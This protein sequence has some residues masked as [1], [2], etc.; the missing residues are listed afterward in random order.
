MSRCANE[1][2]LSDPPASPKADGVS[3][4]R[5][6]SASQASV[7]P[8]SR[9]SCPA[10]SRSMPVTKAGSIRVHGPL[11]NRCVGSGMYPSSAP[12]T[13][14]GTPTAPANSA[15]PTPS[16]EEPSRPASASEIPPTGSFVKILKRIPKASREQC[17]KKL[18]SI[19]D[20]C[21][22]KN[23]HTVWDRLLRFSSRCLRAPRRGGK[24]RSLASAINKQLNEEVDDP[25]ITSAATASHR[26]V[27][28]SPSQDPTKYLATRV[29]LKLEEGDFRGAVRLACSD[30]SL[31]DMTETTYTALQQKH[32]AP[33]PQSSIPQ[34][35][36]RLSFPPV[37]EGEIAQAI[38]SFPNGSAGGPD[39][40]RPQH[41]KD[42]IATGAGVGCEALLCALVPFIE[43]VLSGNTPVSIR[44]FFFGANLIALQKKDGGIRPI[45]V[46]C[47]LRRLAAKVAGM[48]VVDQMATLLAP[49][50]LGYGVRNG[51]EAAVHAARMYLSNPDPS[52]AF[53]KLDFQNA[54]NS[55]RR[56]KMLQ[57]IQELA[58]VLTA[59]AHSAYSL[60]STL[61]WGDKIL[62][63]AEGVQQG[64]P[65]GPLFFCLSIHQLCSSLKSEF[66]VFYLDDC[67]LGGPME[68]VLHDLNIVEREGA[69]LGLHLNYRKS[70]VIGVDKD[71]RDAILSFL[72]GARVVDPLRATLLGSPIGDVSSISITLREKIKLLETL[73]GRLKHLFTHDA[74]I[75]L[76]H[77]LAIPKLLHNLRTSP[78]FLSPTLQDYDELLKST[79]SS[80]ANIRFNEN[81]PAWTQ[82][83]LPVRCGGLG[84]RS[85]VQL[86]PSAFLASA[87]ACSDMIHNIIPSHLQGTPV[88]NVSDAKALWTHGHDMPPPEA[89]AQQVQRSWD[90]IKVT[91]TAERLLE[92]ASDER[93]QARLR[94]AFSKESGAWLQALP[95]SSLGL[96]MDDNTVRVAIGL[97]LGSPLCRPHICH[98]CGVEVDCSA[99][100]GLHCRWS[101]GRHYRHAALNDIVHRALSA[102][103]IPSR[104]EPVGIY[105]SDGKR[106][107]GI[108]VVP[109]ERGQLLVWDA[110]CSD[111]FAPSY[112][113]YATREAGA[114]AAL[115]EERKKA[116]YQH[117][118]ASHCF[119]PIA[120]ETAGAFG[121]QTRAFLK[122]LG[123]RI[124]RATGDERSHS[125]L[126]QRVSVAIQRGNAA[127]VAGTSGQSASLDCFL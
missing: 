8:S 38:K 7:L 40:L 66:S 22:E 102:A 13:V 25:S 3:Q 106:P 36:E 89:N 56:D 53:L 6:G 125:Y 67:S 12:N 120:V 108:T 122:D 121:P 98:H 92:N 52:I 33:H 83:T 119:V 11:G 37:T 65:L 24:R 57:A 73:G 17:G 76:R 109:W 104:L 48:K 62:Q 18:A 126:I 88:P 42:L 31:A 41:L 87:A 93:D 81:D 54:F 77:S 23:D 72:P 60:P 50:Q 2:V 82:A 55:L 26:R 68:D 100:H 105:R 71:T 127:S 110:T 35:P 61:F 115:A 45:A 74:L 29:S 47:T 51:V 30:D 28:K 58:P 10:C 5:D 95:V 97:R 63:S 99:N 16:S 90:S 111:T 27:G 39:G 85:A 70:E 107:D 116:K 44:S 20:A 14:V 117:L 112:T 78:C 4:M 114:V 118:D 34:P 21:V 69:E 79:V 15:E 113:T 124:T 101:E 91:L 46:G 103:K 86:A 32:P 75:L 123:R 1:S 94:A 43:L 80:I 49:R 19:L 59:F 64:D 9:A 96:R 84:I